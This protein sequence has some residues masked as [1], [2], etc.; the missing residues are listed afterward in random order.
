MTSESVPAS[1][2]KL[3]DTYP[4]ILGVPALADDPMLEVVAGFRSRGR[5]PVLSWIHPETHATVTRCAQPLVGMTGK[6]CTEDEKYLSYI[7]E[8]NTHSSKLYIMDARPLVNAVANKAMGGGY[9]NEEVYKKNAEVTFLGE[10]DGCERPVIPDRS[11]QNWRPG[12][13][14]G[15][16]HGLTF[17]FAVKLTSV[18]VRIRRYPQHPRDARVHAEAIGSM[19]PNDRRQ[20]LAV[21]H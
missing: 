18:P 8:A 10:G 5:L 3:C 4:E 16:S 21:Q 11:V 6:R 15:F 17:R 2:Y 9:E 19:F 1:R 20:P 14:P 7:M 12:E 13:T